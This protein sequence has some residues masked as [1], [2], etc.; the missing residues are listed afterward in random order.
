MNK[1][2]EILGKKTI[3]IKMGNK[4]KGKQDRDRM[5]AANMVE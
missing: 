2:L 4:G 5:K 1:E 3:N